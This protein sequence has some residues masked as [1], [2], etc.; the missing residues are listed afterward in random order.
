MLRLLDVRQLAR[1][2]GWLEHVQAALLHAHLTRAHEPQFDG[3][4]SSQQAACWLS[5]SLH[6]HGA[7]RH[8]RGRHSPSWLRASWE[9][10]CWR[11]C[12]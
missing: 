9:A 8:S 5:G 4:R 10:A 1:R 2:Q 6:R 7:A 3:L 12:C 11:A